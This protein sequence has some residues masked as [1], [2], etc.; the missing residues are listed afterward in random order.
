ML[1]IVVTEMDYLLFQIDVEVTVSSQRMT[2]NEI[3]PVGASVGRVFATVRTYLS[4]C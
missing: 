2:D 4:H 3:Q 1:T